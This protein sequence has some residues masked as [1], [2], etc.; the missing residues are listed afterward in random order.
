MVHLVEDL[1]QPLHL[2]GRAR[3]GNDWMVKFDGYR[4]NLHRVWD[5]LGLMKRMHQVH[6]SLDSAYHK[7]RQISVESNKIVTVDN[8]E[9]FEEANLSLN[10]HTSPVVPISDLKRSYIAY[11]KAMLENPTYSAVI[12]SWLYC[13]ASDVA[14]GAHHGCPEYWAKDISPLNCQ[15]TWSIANDKENQ[16]LGEEYW[17]KIENDMVFETIIMKAAIRLAA[18]LNSCFDEH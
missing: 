17:A 10:N 2:S 4:V 3:G 13:P 9:M 16:D 12:D 18:V 14:P 1:H 8:V 6:G 15:Y 5:N 7:S 11:L